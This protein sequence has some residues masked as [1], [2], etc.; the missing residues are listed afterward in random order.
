MSYINY[1]V[2]NNNRGVF[3]YLQITLEGETDSDRIMV[4]FHRLV[5][6]LK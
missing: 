5:E 2:M 1:T 3:Q 6:I 4:G